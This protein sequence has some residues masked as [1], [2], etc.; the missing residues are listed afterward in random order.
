LSKKGA[1]DAFQI[2]S[3][4]KG[5]QGD[6]VM[7]SYTKQLGDDLENLRTGRR[8]DVRS[9]DQMLRGTGNVR[10]SDG[11]VN[12]ADDLKGQIAKF[13]SNKLDM[14]KTTLAN[15]LTVRDANG[16]TNGA[17]TAELSSQLFGNVNARE[18]DM[19]LAKASGDKAIK[20]GGVV[21]AIGAEKV[22]ANLN[23]QAL[24]SMSD[25]AAKVLSAAGALN[26]IDS[27]IASTILKNPNTSAKITSPE[28]MQA[29]QTASTRITQSAEQAAQQAYA[30]V[31]LHQEAHQ[32]A[33]LPFAGNLSQSEIDTIIKPATDKAEQ[34]AKANAAV[35]GLQQRKLDHETIQ[36]FHQQGND[37]TSGGGV[38]NHN[39]SFWLG[40]LG[41]NFRLLVLNNNLI[42]GRI[43]YA[44]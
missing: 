43:G 38:L 36:F 18:F 27:R 33:N 6:A 29:L 34:Q 12:A 28:L 10:N 31:P 37:D 15:F 8:T 21:D 39:R 16:E 2:L 44:R 4:R 30:S 1:S 9:F 14:S 23:A 3:A 25:D 24:T 19:M 5:L 35:A 20:L 40:E 22:G 13:D 42:Q 17:A 32:E 26:H 7:L 11:T 41:W